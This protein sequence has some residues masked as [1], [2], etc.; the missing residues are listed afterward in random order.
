MRPDGKTCVARYGDVVPPTT[1][2]DTIAALKPAVQQWVRGWMQS[3]ATRQRAVDM[4][5]RDGEQF[6][7]VG[8]AGVL[9]DC[10]AAVAAA[11][12]A[13][14]SP[15]HVRAAW[16]AL[17]PSLT[18]RQV[19][20]A[21]AQQAFEWGDGELPRFGDATLERLD[22]LGRRVVDAADGSLGGVFA[23]W[24]AAPTSASLAARVALTMHVVR[25]MRG[26]AHIVALN[27]VGMTPLQ[28]VLASPAAPP[29]TGPPWAEHLG[30]TGPFEDP[31]QFVALR[32]EA[33]DL[34]NRILVPAFD[35][36]DSAEL[37]EFAELCTS[38]RNAIE[39]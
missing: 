33:E 12:L 16:D 15:A 36:L 2:I 22:A 26:A 18:H 11:G 31:A 24:R 17:P 21:Y 10:D 19:A 38:V 20:A 7:I 14:L 29:R 13:F 35:A 23:G 39:M 9:G 25:E 37:A 3:P 8:R 4:G 27:A 30:W 1:T 5:L 34:T 32:A 28:S 6:W